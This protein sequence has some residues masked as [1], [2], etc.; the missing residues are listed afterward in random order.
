MALWGSS[1]CRLPRRYWSERVLD[2]EC[3]E[4]AAFVAESLSWH[5]DG[6]V[7]AVKVQLFA[8]MRQG[9]R[10]MYFDTSVPR[11]LSIA[12]QP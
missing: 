2:E 3:Q 7:R 4:V 6:S 1:S 5:G 10:A 12:E 9:S 8:D 11:T